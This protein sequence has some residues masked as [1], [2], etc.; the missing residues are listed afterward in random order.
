M[1]SF[2]KCAVC[3]QPWNECQAT[4]EVISERLPDDQGV[5]R[6]SVEGINA[7][8]TGN[9]DTTK[10]NVEPR[11][12]GETTADMD[13]GIPGS[14][15]GAVIGEMVRLIEQARAVSSELESVKLRLVHATL[16]AQTFLD[17]QLKEEK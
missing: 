11:K 5:L 1:G 16:R 15:I 13:R 12:H 2:G 4:K 10:S 9:D 17:W 7:G 14:N 6:K 8:P 3:G